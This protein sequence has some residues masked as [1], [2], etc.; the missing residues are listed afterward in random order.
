MFADLGSNETNVNH[1]AT[2][3]KVQK[4]KTVKESIWVDKDPSNYVFFMESRTSKKMSLPS[5]QL[6]MD[7]I[8]QFDD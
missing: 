8:Q 4:T 3:A 5:K 7:T 2:R 1:Y 6:I